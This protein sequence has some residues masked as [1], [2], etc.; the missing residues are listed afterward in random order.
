[1]MFFFQS[2]LF[3]LP[4]YFATSL[5]VPLRYFATSLLISLPLL[6]FSQALLFQQ[7]A[8]T[9][10]NEDQIAMQLFQAKNFEKAAELYSRIY[11][12]KPTFY[13]YSYYFFCLVEIREYDEARKL[14]K[15]QQ[16]ADPNT[17]KYQVDLGYLY[18]REGNAEKSKKQYEEALKR[19][20]PDP[21]QVYDLANA[22]YS[23]GEY[24]YAIRAYKKGREILPPTY[25]FGFELAGVY[26]R[27][28]N[29][30]GAFEEYLYMLT[31]NK[32]FESLVRDRLQNVLL[33][34]NDNSK[35]EMFRKLVLSHIQKE[36]AKTCYSELLLWYSMQQKDFELA[37][38]QAKALDRRQKEAGDRIMELAALSIS[39]GDY[40]VAE[41]AY[42]Y[43]ISKGQSC[44]YYEAARRE[45]LHTRYIRYTADQ[46]TKPKEYQE[47]KA[48]MNT[49]LSLWENNPEAVPIALDL[50]HLETFYLNT[51]D[52][53]LDLLDRVLDWKG[54]PPKQSAEVKMELADIHLYRGDMWTSTVFYQQV[55]KDFKNDVTGQ[56]AKFRNARL[57]YYMGEFKWAKAQLD[58]LKAATTKFIAND[59]LELSML[60]GNNYDPDS[61]TVALGIYSRAELADFRNR[62][63][64]ALQTLDSIPMLFKE[65]PI[66]DNVTYRKGEICFKQG[67]Y[68]L[69]DS[70]F[71]IVIR[72]H[73]EDIIT[74]EAIMNRAM[75]HE[76]W[77]ADTRGAMDLYQE[78]LNNHQGSLFTPEARKRYR[79]LRGDNLK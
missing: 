34:D 39:N 12:K 20:P 22:F 7:D 54:L 23:K 38:I 51:P 65:H 8:V 37:L 72:N 76:T 11:P 60:I 13:N 62:E 45:M 53:A 49:E 15:A 46:A 35:N 4:R 75:I 30:E 52:E 68:T 78:L 29:F 63:D 56:D 27:N 59:A 10:D 69:A 6:T 2:K 24:E 32:N 48:S 47:L 17:L 70:L 42:T 55:Y 28:G 1:M 64:L 67:K 18:F 26:E 79:V 14:I 33:E 66:L 44:E 50:A 41:D 25:A 61:G 40:K 74:D 21:S 31:L 58:V 16:K 43:L 71:A 77:L 57:S 5:L 19:L 73:P 3:S 36:P 9:A